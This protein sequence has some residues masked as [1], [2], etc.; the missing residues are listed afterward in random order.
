MGHRR[1]DQE[2]ADREHR[3]IPGG[4]GG[5]A[6]RLVGGHQWHRCVVPEKPDEKVIVCEEPLTTFVEIAV[7]LKYPPG[8]TPE[9]LFILPK[10]TKSIHIK[11][12]FWPFEAQYVTGGA[13]AVV[14]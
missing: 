8:S 13:L 5:G 10:L 4:L 6:Y 7:P 14:N 11:L 2:A 3:R 1:H 12:V 9:V